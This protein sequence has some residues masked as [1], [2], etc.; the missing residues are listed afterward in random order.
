MNR[1]PILVNMSA[2]VEDMSKSNE[3]PPGLE[4]A[5]HNREV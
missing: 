4:A 2:D 1:Y 3:Q 5:S